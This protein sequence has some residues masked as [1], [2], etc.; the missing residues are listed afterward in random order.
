M[1]GIICAQRESEEEN[2]FLI[3]FQLYRINM[4]QLAEQKGTTAFFLN[5]IITF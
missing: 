5:R 4:E 2:P 3:T 1:R